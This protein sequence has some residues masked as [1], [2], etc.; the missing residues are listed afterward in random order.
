MHIL[1]V[2]VPDA[3]GG[4]L[5]EA[6]AK[7]HQVSTFDGDPLDREACATVA[8]CD[9]LVHGL[10]DSGDPLHAIDLASR[11]TWNLLTTTAARRY[12]LL[13]SMRVFNAYDPGWHVTEAWSPRPSTDPDELV[14][15]LAEVASREISRSRPI[16]CVV[17]RLD[18]VVPADRFEAGPVES[19]WLHEDDAIEAICRS[20]TVERVSPAG[21]RWT[22]LHIVR[23]GASSRFPA[24]NA[25]AEPF[26]F[27]AR[28][29][30]DVPNHPTPDAPVVPELPAP[31]T[32]LPVPERIVIF[33]AGGPLGAVTASLLRDDHRLRLTD[34]R[35][36]QEVAQLPPQSPGAP[37]PEPPQ[38]PHEELVV[39][40][41]DPD[42]VYRA[43]TGM[44]AIVNCTVVRNDPVQAFRVNTLGAYNVMKA[45][46]DLGIQRVV[47]TGPVLTLAPHP[48]GYTDDRDVDANLPPRPGDNLYFVSKFVGQEICRIFA[49][50][51]RIACPTLLFSG[52][53]NPA[54]D[55]GVPGPFTISWNDSGRAMAAAVG[56]N[57]LSAP[58]EVLHILADAPH[59]RYRGDRARLVLDWEPQDRLD[60]LWRRRL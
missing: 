8:G 36:L 20:V 39:D 33:G 34:V 59:D 18:E 37:L 2:G 43:A 41:T 42:A 26:G 13:S 60:A 40:V 47:H 12:V 49:E 25:T 28:H 31:L 48:A 9:I 56:V 46:A 32:E 51:H 1:L 6:L 3:I 27:V 4:S 53:L 19:Q 17:L 14:P 16:E 5:V 54:V 30:A 22:P 50:Q 44:D 23:G 35:P 55:G 10:P 29:Q 52:F 58:F 11:G 24:G 15:Y 38:P 7:E 45:A 21:S 57:Q